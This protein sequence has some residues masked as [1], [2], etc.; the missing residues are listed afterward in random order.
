MSRGA[1]AAI[2]DG[3]SVAGGL[4]RRS[5]DMLATSVAV[6]ERTAGDVLFLQDEVDAPVYY[7][8]VAGAVRTS[9]RDGAAQDVPAG[10]AFG[11]EALAA[12]D[13]PRAST[14]LVSVTPTTL[15]TVTRSAYLAATASR[16]AS[17]AVGASARDMGLA[18]LHK[19]PNARGYVVLVL[20]VLVLLV[21][22]LLVLLVLL[23]LLL[24]LPLLLLLVLLLALV[25]PC[26]LTQLLQLQ[27]QL[28]HLQVVVTL[29][30]VHF[31]V[32]LQPL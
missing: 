6:I 26:V 1:L 19:K 23:L 30:V 10:Q 24:L 14:A 25:L 5:V 16:R 3:L 11:E 2:V 12:D 9:V 21:L 31:A 27:L 18:A 17:F 29:N 4:D 22:L 20:L 15:L 32:H 8:V 28:V 7:L 13:M